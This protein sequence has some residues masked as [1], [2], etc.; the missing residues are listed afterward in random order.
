VHAHTGFLHH[1]IACL[2]VKVG[3]VAELAQRHEAA[4]DV[5]D[6][7]FDDPLLLRIPRGTGVDLE[8]VSLGTLGVCAL[9]TL[10]I[11]GARSVIYRV[12]QRL[13]ETSWLRKLM[14][15]RN[16]N[17]AAVALANKTA[18]TVWALL[19]HDREFDA[20]HK[21]ARPATAIAA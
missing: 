3:K 18:R 13:E 11:H 8:A 4:L 10:L 5:F 19:R 14:T 21:A 17:V 15:R 9:R 6:S 16:V 12:S 1:P 20:A 7:R 2:G